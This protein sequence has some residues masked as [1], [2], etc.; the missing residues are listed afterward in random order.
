MNRQQILSRLGRRG[1]N[2]VYSYGRHAI[3]QRHTESF[4]RLPLL[5]AFEPSD[6]VT[7]D[8]PGKLLLRSGQLNGLDALTLKLHGA[9]LRKKALERNGK[10]AALIYHPRFAAYADLLKPDYLIF[11]LRDAYFGELGWQPEDQRLFER[12]AARADLIVASH[13]Q[14]ASPVAEDRRHRILE[15]PNA[16]AFEHFCAG[17][18]RPEPADLA[19]IPGPRIG[20]VGSINMKVDLQLL[21]YLAKR[22]PDWSLVLVGPLVA[23]RGD[24][25]PRQWEELLATPNVHWLGS[26][27]VGELPAYTAHIDVH[28]LC[29]DIVGA[30][31]MRFGSPLKLYECL[32]AGRPVVSTPIEAVSEI[33]GAVRLA[34][35]PQEWE[36]AIVASLSESGD[37]HV[38]GRQ[39]I[40]AKNDWDVRVDLLE[41]HLFRLARG[42]QP[43]IAA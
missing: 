39:A 29:Y 23:F 32:A 19:A 14:M 15:L 41:E 3:W 42:T 13:L 34:E 35:T 27:A 43:S 9:H 11:Y 17:S 1:W 5:P 18:L 2:V 37:T 4:Q 40:A 7:V 10:L 28:L 16:V 25:K 33:D 38:K 22:R 20:Y 24:E 36:A 26:K 6:N 12:L 21:L 31:W 8:Q 30:P